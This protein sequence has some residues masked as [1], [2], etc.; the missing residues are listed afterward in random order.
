MCQVLIGLSVYAIDT[1]HTG[2]KHHGTT[3][4]VI[5]LDKMPPGEMENF[6][7]I[8]LTTRVNKTVCLYQPDVTRFYSTDH[9]VINLR[10]FMVFF[11]T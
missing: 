8:V 7:F 11:R 9:F 2:L 10:L 4:S 1:T 5:L 3:L 6:N